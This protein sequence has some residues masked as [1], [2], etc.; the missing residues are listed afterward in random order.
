M[1]YKAPYAL[2]GNGPEPLHS[3]IKERLKL[4]K[5]FF[6]VDGGAD[7]LIQMGYT[8]DIIL[9]DMDSV[10]QKREQYNCKIVP[11]ENQSQNDMEKSLSWCVDNGIKELDLFGFSY[12]R[13]D[14]HLAS[15]IIMK[16]YSDRIKMKMYTENS[17]I[18]CI[19]DHTTFPSLPDQT[20]SLITLNRKTK[21]STTGL[22]YSLNNEV[23]N[24]PG[25]GISNAAN[26]TNFSV[27]PS[28]WVWVIMNYIQ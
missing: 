12:G 25:H 28:D 11:L 22:K 5:T 15:L 14:Q 4:I 20:I 6:C 21:I 17:L 24:S 27:H 19:N 3:I 26:G 18:F 10:T 2:F 9:G 13:D 23:L 16:N 8:P 7:K 1:D